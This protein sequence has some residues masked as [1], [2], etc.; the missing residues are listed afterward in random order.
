MRTV[1]ASLISAALTMT[2]TN[3]VVSDPFRIEHLRG[4]SIQAVWTGTPA[5]NFQVQGSNDLGQYDGETVTGLTNWSNI[6][7]TVAAGGAAGS[8][9]F[10]LD[11]A[12]YRWVRLSYTNTSSTGSITSVRANAKE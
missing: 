9:M 12:H 2:S 1:N 8:N 7:A 10:N 11:G 5:G 3:T 4:V 6:G